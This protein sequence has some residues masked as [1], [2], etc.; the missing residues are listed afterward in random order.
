MT[1]RWVKLWTGNVILTTAAIA[2]SPC[3]FS[4]TTC[5]YSGKNLTSIPYDLPANTTKLKLMNNNIS[6]TYSDVQILS[7]LTQLKELYLGHNLI[8][9]LLSG[10]FNN[11]KKL[12]ILELHSNCLAH[13]EKDIMKPL[14]L[15]HLTLYGNH[16]NCSC[17][18]LGF[19]RWLNE[20]QVHLGNAN[21]TTCEAPEEMQ[22]STFEEAL[23]KRNG[24]SSDSSLTSSPDK[25]TVK[26][27]FGTT[28]SE[29]MHNA[30]MQ[31]PTVA[32]QNNTAN[33][34]NGSDQSKFGKSWKLVAG[35]MATSIGIS[36]MLVLFAKFIKWYN[37]LFAYHHHR[38]QE[39]PD[40]YMESTPTQTTHNVPQTSE[41]AKS[42]KQ[43][44]E[45]RSIPHNVSDDDEY[46]EDFYIDSIGFTNYEQ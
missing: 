19:Q 32:G 31:S 43:E 34:I 22:F 7:N 6:L 14:N 18:F 24:C 27:T 15:S 38:L 11:F 45:A 30:A 28:L 4:D 46:I 1:T 41:E 33:Q 39:E 9:K 42:N 23:I 8:C 21:I 40:L 44:T 3:N 12:D 29:S 10:T 36:L 2:L 26:S 16:W 5:D 25:S 17:G 35:V 13:V 37:C 20:S